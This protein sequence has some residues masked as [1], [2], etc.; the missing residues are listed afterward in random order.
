MLL[1]IAATRQHRFRSDVL[2]I[3]LHTQAEAC[4]VM[5]ADE[6]LAE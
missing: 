5:N 3:I 1:L 6:G 4:Q 2:K